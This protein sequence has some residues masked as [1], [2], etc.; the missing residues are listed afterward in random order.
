MVSDRLRSVLLGAF[1]AV[2]IAL[3]AIGLYGVLSYTVIQRKR[4]LGIRAA[5]GANPA[6]LIVLVVGRG[7]RMTAHGLVLGIAGALVANRLLSAFIFGVKPSDATII[8]TAAAALTAVAL[9]AC[10][11]PAR[12]AASV[13]P[14]VALRS[15]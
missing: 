3:A 11:I 7:M 4:E 2:A 1:A 8:G 5:L 13:D 14:M 9:L 6:A 12:R 15:E 10:C